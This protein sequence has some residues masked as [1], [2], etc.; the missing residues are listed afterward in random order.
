VARRHRLSVVGLFAGIGGLE[1]GLHAAG[2]ETVFLCEIDSAACR[3]LRA[4]FDL[5]PHRDIASLRD[6]PS[7]DVVVAGFPCQDLSQAG[8]TQGIDGSQSGLVQHVFRLLRGRH[9]VRWLLLEN[10]PFMLRLDRGRA[11]EYLVQRLESAGF[12]WAYRVVDSRA[13]GL[14]QRRERVVLLASRVEDPAAALLADD[15]G[16]PAEPD[17]YRVA[18][19]FYW[20]EGNRGLGWAVDAVPALKGGSGLGIPSPPAIRLPRAG[21]IVT[22]DIRDAERLQGFE[23]DW[24]LPAD[25]ES[26]SRGVRWRLVGNAVSPPLARWVGERLVVHSTTRRTVEGR[27]FT[28]APWPRAAYGEN[29]NRFAVDVSQRPMRYQ[30]PSLGDFMVFA[31]TKLSVRATEG[32]LGRLRQSSLRTEPWF[33]PELEL[34]LTTMRAAAA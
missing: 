16:P 33:I 4:Q 11:M 1:H 2:H 8:R 17:P 34:H 14:P 5:E 26:T 31:P 32:F 13:F 19:G 24:T 27:P 29:G 10:V 28:T 9:D 22:P 20:T 25:E 6:F 12:R 3:V 30:T 18:C 7:A 21:G 15:E 23:P